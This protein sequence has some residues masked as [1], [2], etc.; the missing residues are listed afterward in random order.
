MGKFWLHTTAWA[1]FLTDSLNTTLV[2]FI[3]DDTLVL[4][5][6]APPGRMAVGPADADDRDITGAEA[7]VGPGVGAGEVELEAFSACLSGR[8]SEQF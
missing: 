8:V 4:R 3:L 5:E 6:I 1:E 2:K 7:G